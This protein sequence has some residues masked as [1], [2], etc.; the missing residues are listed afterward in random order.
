MNHP[1]FN[2][3]IYLD[4]FPPQFQSTAAA[5]CLLKFN[6]AVFA[7]WKHFLLMPSRRIWGR[8]LWRTWNVW[9]AP[10]SKS[11]FKSNN[12]VKRS[13]T[14]QVTIAEKNCLLEY[15]FEYSL[16]IHIN[17]YKCIND[18]EVRHVYLRSTANQLHVR[19]VT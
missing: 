4:Y 13:L 11:K 1:W 17:I 2:C 3:Y 10:A 9:T 5:M 19:H 15:C 14:T 6:S 12:V 16:H 7:L 8:F 18:L